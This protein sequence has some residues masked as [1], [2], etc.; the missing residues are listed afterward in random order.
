[1]NR[2]GWEH[3]EL[4]KEVFNSNLAQLLEL[5][6]R[7]SEKYTNKCV[8]YTKSIGKLTEDGKKELEEEAILINEGREKIALHIAEIL[9]DV[10]RIQRHI[11]PER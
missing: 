9:T 10:K 7:E 1:M 5:F 2:T 3:Y 4:E 6:K 11:I 8:D